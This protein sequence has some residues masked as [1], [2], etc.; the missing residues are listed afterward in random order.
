MGLIGW[1]LKVDDGQERKEARRAKSLFVDGSWGVGERW[2][3][4]QVM[5]EPKIVGKRRISKDDGESEDL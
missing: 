4:R 3:Y 5:R 2:M 1:L